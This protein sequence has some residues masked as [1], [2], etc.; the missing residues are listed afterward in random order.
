MNPA[1]ELYR[2]EW[3]NMEHQRQI[4]LALANLRAM[5]APLPA[6]MGSPLDCLAPIYRAQGE[7]CAH[8]ALLEAV[9]SLDKS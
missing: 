5:Y 8:L 2:L 9:A 4:K 7:A 3:D 6:N 1:D